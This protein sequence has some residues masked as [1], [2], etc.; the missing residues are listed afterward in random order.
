MHPHTSPL[1][2][3]HRA[4]GPQRSVPNMSVQ[5]GSPSHVQ[6]GPS[7]TKFSAGLTAVGAPLNGR[8]AERT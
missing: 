6:T 1:V 3:S 7:Q 4:T 2:E 5:S 8:A